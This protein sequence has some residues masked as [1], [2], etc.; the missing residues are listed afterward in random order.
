MTSFRTLCGAVAGVALCAAAPAVAADNWPSRTIQVISPFSAGNAN[1]L[2]ARVVLD[3]VSRQ[4]GQSFV[5]ENRPGGGGSLGAATVA[6]AD[7]DGYTVLLY[8]S[9][10]SGQVVLHK[11]LPF[12]PVRDFVPVVMF[13]VQ[14]SVL[15]AAPEKGWKSLADLVAAAKA[16]PGALNFASAGVGSAS[17]MAGER[18]RLAAD[19]KAQHIPFRGP[20][21]AFT[22]VMAGRVDYYYLPI[23]PALPNI[24]NGKVVALAV[25]TPK[26]SS[27]LPDVPTVREA[28]YPTA[29]YLF[30]GGLAVPA[31]T[32]R[33]I[34]DRLH[35]ETR[36]A[37]EIPAV[38][39]RLE[40]LGVQAMP[41]SVDEFAKFTRDDVAATI[42]LA[43]EINL[44]PTN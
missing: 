34:V 26:R 40:T 18:L 13:G 23:A 42:N 7:P 6:K 43:R 9:S 29:A 11:S 33:A 37:L 2:V 35:S 44:V 28:G 15:V 41:L 16:R 38:Q 10:L 20:I 1:D 19:I 32:P 17:H 24:Q 3:A 4:L 21:E 25:S 14:P 22:E 30:W 31:N 5:I 36:K 27:L 8:S 12:D 39:Q